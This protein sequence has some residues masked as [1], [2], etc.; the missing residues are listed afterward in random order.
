MRYGGDTLNDRKC[1]DGFLRQRKSIK[2]IGGIRRK[3]IE[4]GD[5]FQSR[6]PHRLDEFD[7][8]FLGGLLPSRARLRFTSYAIV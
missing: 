6:P 5:C 3:I 8:L 7:W 2:P 1:E 4:G